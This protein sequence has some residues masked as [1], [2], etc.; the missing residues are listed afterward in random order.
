M[1]DKFLKHIQK[2]AAFLFQKKLLLAVSGG[3]DSVVLVD[4]FYK[5]GFTIGMAHVNFQLRGKESDEDALFVASW[6]KQLQLAFFLKKTDTKAY[7]RMHKLSVQMAARELRYRWFDALLQTHNYD[8]LLTG[9]HLND[10]VETFFINLSRRS[11]LQGLLG[12]P[13]VQGKVIRPLLPFTREE[14]MQYAQKNKLHWR[15]DASNAGNKYVRNQIRHI[16][17]PALTRID[18]GFVQAINHSQKHLQNAQYLVTDYINDVKKITGFHGEQPVINIRKLQSFPHPDAVLYELLKDYGFEDWDSVYQLPAAQTG[19]RVFSQTHVL[20]KDRENLVLSVISTPVLPAQ[21]TI[22]GEGFEI[23][24]QTYVLQ[25]VNRKFD[26]KLTTKNRHSI[27]LDHQKI[28]YPLFIRKWKA[29]DTFYP[30]GMQK[31]KKLSDFFIN[32]K[33]SRF[34]KEKIYLLCDSNDAIVWV[35]GQRIDDRFKITN[36]T[37]KILKISLQHE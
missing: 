21:K 33:L 7:A 20:L 31:K 23:D 16:L 27:L 25:V 13:E 29:G 18:P 28:H 34:E 24:G 32:Q 36:N 1:F 9:H 17:I 15:E 37:T 19:K 6:A 30:L 35:I 4:L 3:V 11:G 14:I 2:N 22:V 10:T 8:Y 12:I 5:A 26:L